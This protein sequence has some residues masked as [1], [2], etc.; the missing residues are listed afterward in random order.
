MFLYKIHFQ[1]S[2]TY[3]NKKSRTHCYKKS[4]TLFW[5]S[6]LQMCV[7]CLK[8]VVYLVSVQEFI[9][10]SPQKAFLRKILLTMKT[11]KSNTFFKTFFDIL[12]SVYFLLKSTF[13]SGQK[14]PSFTEAEKFEFYEIISQIYCIFLLKLN[15][16]EIIIK[17]DLKS[18][19]LL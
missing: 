17:K 16:Q 4:G 2:S 3:C 11:I 19:D 1:N 13:L 5:K 9:K 12:P 14:T 8:F 10:C 15:K 6:L 7:Q 18:F